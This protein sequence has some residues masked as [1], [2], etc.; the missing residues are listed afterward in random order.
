MQ[1]WDT[2]IFKSHGA[3]VRGY[4]LIPEKMWDDL[5]LLAKYLNEGYEYVMS[6]EAK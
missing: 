4:V 3:V 1:E 6:L 5:D 2:T